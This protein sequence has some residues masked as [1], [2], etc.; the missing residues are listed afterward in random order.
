MANANIS[1]DDKQAG[2]PHQTNRSYSKDTLLQEYGGY[3]TGDFRQAAIKIQ[4]ANGAQASDFRFQSFKTESMLIKEQMNIILEMN[5]CQ[6]VY[7]TRQ[8]S[9]LILPL[10][11]VIS[12]GKLNK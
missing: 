9:K 11:Y 4:G 1:F 8:L 7:I 10:R 3:N 12:N 5:S 2:K 6:L